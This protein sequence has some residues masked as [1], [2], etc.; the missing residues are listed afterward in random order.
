MG[1]LPY[2]WARKIRSTTSGDARPCPRKEIAHARSL[3][4]RISKF[5]WNGLTLWWWCGMVQNVSGLAPRTLY[6]G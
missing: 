4:G 2:V 5:F 1:T 6:G 3:S